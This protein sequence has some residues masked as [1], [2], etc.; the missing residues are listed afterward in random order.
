VS[1]R[2]ASASHPPTIVL[3]EDQHWWFASRTRA[4]LGML[5]RFLEPDGAGRRVLDVGCGAGNMFHHLARY[6]DVEGLDSNPKPLT[7]ARQRGYR[8]QQASAL[9]MPYED[10]RFD[11]VAA[12]DVVEHVPDDVALLKECYRVCRPG[13]F[14]VTTVPAFQWLWSHNDE[15]NGHQRRYRRQE[16]A[17]RLRGAGFRTRRITFNNFLIFP[18]AA[19]MILLRRNAA[20]EPTL[21]APST[22]EEA[23]QVEMEPAPPALNAILGALGSAEAWVLR[24]TDLPAGTSLIGI[25]QK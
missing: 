21:A 24:R 6:G 14:L 13:G 18:L 22:D 4:L 16:L 1:N 5:D 9:Q 2:T 20:K 25:A 11:L 15:I 19:G 12:L 8:V 10:G 7:I 23:Y 3:A 17:E